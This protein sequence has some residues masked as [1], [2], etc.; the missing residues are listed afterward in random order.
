[1]RIRGTVL[2][3]YEKSVVILTP[4]GE[5][6]EIPR[7]SQC[8]LGQALTYV[9]ERG[10]TSFLTKILVATAATLMVF[11][12]LGQVEISE[13]YAPGDLRPLTA[14]VPAPQQA[15]APATSSKTTKYY[16]SLSICS[17]LELVTDPGGIIVAVQ[18]PGPGPSDIADVVALRGKHIRDGLIELVRAFLTPEAVRGDGILLVAVASDASDEERQ[19]IALDLASH[20]QATLPKLGFNATPVVALAG[21][22]ASREA[23]C[24]ENLPVGLYLA[25][26][27]ARKQG[28]NVTLEDFRLKGLQAALEEA[29]G[30]W[31][32]ILNGNQLASGALLQAAQ[33]KALPAQGASWA[34]VSG[35]R[36]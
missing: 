8:E 35:Q 26:L 32:G 21:D 2:E 5:F 6:R 10:V 17:G 34:S 3:I 16:V 28:V 24:S 11:V 15:V 7:P 30:T 31:P 36:R 1:M 13:R 12:L 33:N 18:A 20:L 9:S 19:G 23:A 27:K 22:L 25:Y 14:G 29:G 4:D